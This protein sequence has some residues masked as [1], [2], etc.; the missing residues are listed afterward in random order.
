VSARRACR[1]WLVLAIALAG[2]K[3]AAT[4][5][6]EHATD[7][8]FAQRCVPCHGAEGKGNGPLAPTYAVKPRDWSTMPPLDPQRVRR[9]VVEGGMGIG[10]SPVMPPNPD[11]EGKPVVVEG[12]VAKVRKLGAPK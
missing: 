11:L 8:L 3:D 9:A 12:L 7:A 5:A 10:M 1:L 2:C 4:E 6:Q